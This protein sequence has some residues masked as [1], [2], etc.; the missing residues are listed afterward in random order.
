MIDLIVPQDKLFTF[1]VQVLKFRAKDMHIG[2]V[3]YQ[4]RN[5]RTSSSLNSAFY[6][7]A[8]ILEYGV[9]YSSSLFRFSSEKSNQGRGFREGD[10]I[11]VEVELEKGKIRFMVNGR[12]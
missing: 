11:V 1:Q 9:G 6:T 10:I 12:R 4:T 8:G 7:G 2:I 3:D 5:S